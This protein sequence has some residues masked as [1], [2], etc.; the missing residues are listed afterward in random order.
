VAEHTE[1][2]ADRCERELTRLFDRGERTRTFDVWLD[3]VGLPSSYSAAMIQAY[4]R[5]RP[6]L[7]LHD[8]AAAAINWCSQAHLLT[9]LVSDGYLDVQRAKVASLGLADL[10]TTIVLSDEFGRAFW[11]PA[12]RPYLAAV[13]S[14]GVAPDEA[15]YVGDNP[16]KDFEGARRSGLKSVRVRRS[17]GMYASEEAASPDAEPD[18]EIVT[19]LDLQEVLSV[20]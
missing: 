14:L 5:H 7:T 12:T 13:D 6:L 3:A 2:P 9:G 4:R 10:L 20:L 15:V 8:D 1:L 17:D 19:L 16:R 18:H 11:K